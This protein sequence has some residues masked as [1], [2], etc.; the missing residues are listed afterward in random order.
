MSNL[1]GDMPLTC[2]NCGH[3]FK[4]DITTEKNPICPDC[5]LIIDAQQFREGMSEAEKSIEDLK[6]EIED[7]NLD[8]D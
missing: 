5:G 6:K 7:F 4:M 2:P 3:T 1:S 8:F